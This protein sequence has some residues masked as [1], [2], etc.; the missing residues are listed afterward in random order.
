MN[1]ELEHSR[2]QSEFLSYAYALQ[3]HLALYADC[4]AG[5]AFNQPPLAFTRALETVC[6]TIVSTRASIA[7]SNHGMLVIDGPETAAT[8]EQRRRLS[9]MLASTLL[10]PNEVLTERQLAETRELLSRLGAASTT[11]VANG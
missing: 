11:A 9:L 8:A 6:T 4:L 2:L 3:F 7:S 1:S 10:G 5:M